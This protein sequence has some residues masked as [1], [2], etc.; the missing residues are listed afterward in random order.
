M[1]SA[2]K[3]SFFSNRLLDLPSTVWT[4]AAATP[5][6]Q[7][8]WLAFSPEALALIGAEAE[9]WQ[10]S[11]MLQR[12]N[13]EQ[14]FASHDP[15]VTV[16][17]GHQFGVY[18]PQ[19]GDGRALWL[20]EFQHPEHGCWELQVKG[21]GPT[22]YSRQG[23]GRAVLRSSIREFLA[24]EAMHH[25]GIASTRA[26]CLIGSEHPVWREQKETG[27]L[28]LRLAPSFLRF[29]SMEYFAHRG[30]RDTLAQLVAFMRRHHGPAL[31]LDAA[32][33]PPAWQLFNAVLA[34]S[35]ELAAAWQAVGFCHG[36]LNT[37]N[38]SL[39]G[40]TLDY[41]PFAFMDG[42][43]PGFICNH[44]DHQGRYAFSAQP[45]IVW[46][47]LQCL[48][49]ALA[50]LEPESDWQQ[51]L[52]RYPEQFNAHYLRTM[53]AKLGLQQAQP[54]DVSLLEQLFTLMAEQTVD[55][56]CFFRRL[57]HIHAETSPQGLADLVPELAPWQAWW[58]AYQS[59]LAQE[60]D[61]AAVDAAAL[62]RARML[63]INPKYILRNHLA[64]QAIRLAEQGDA[65][66]VQ[67]LQQLL[68]QPYAEQPAF[69]A[70]AAPA[71]AWAR[72]LSLSCS[73]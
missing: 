41:G 21:S 62:R 40:L 14:A 31:G 47:N 7:A 73:S 43:D 45:E 24:S 10:Q 32:E 71:P 1:F 39:L 22:V 68:T 60:P 23:D 51:A 28:V 53:R 42:F 72:E 56:T 49:Q 59:R 25:L 3:N 50:V 70:Y 37:D 19:L 64:E 34:R 8:R 65:S 9:H 5:L 66:E 35:A 52:A 58:A 17:A 46:W 4:A 38:M 61:A 63:Q 27:A 29:G 13:G 6:R 2:A 11:D 26:A 33:E 57:A 15:V 55:Y 16:Y 48:A 30:D 12:L 44:S 69:E 20:G 54:D 67:R 18:V 36:V